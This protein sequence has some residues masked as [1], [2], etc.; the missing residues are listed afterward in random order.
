MI[1][2]VDSNI[3]RYYVQALC[4]VFFPGAKF[5][6]NEQLTPE[7]PIV[8]VSTSENEEGVSAIASFTIGDKCVRAEHTEPHIKSNVK[9]DTKKVAVGV[10]VFKVGEKFFKYSPSWGILTGVRPSKIA[11]DLL[12]KGLSVSEIKSIFTK[13]YFINPKKAALVIN[14][15][16]NEAKKIKTLEENTCSL[17]ISIPFCPTRCSYCSF[18]S[19]STNRLLSL[20]PDYIEKLLSDLDDT[21]QLIRELNQKIITVYIGGGTPSILS[22]EQLQMLF[23]KINDNIDV[24]SLSEYTFEAGRP[25]TITSEKLK[26]AK[27]MGVNRISINPQTLN[28]AVLETIGRRHTADD[29]YKAYDIVRESGIQCINTDLIAGLP[30]E[31]FSSFSK[32]V[33]AILK[34]HPENI[35]F[36]TFCVK[37][38]ADV[39]KNDKNIYSRVIGHTGQSVDYAQLEAKNAGYIPYYMYRQKNTIGNYENVGFSLEGFEG[40]YNIYMM[41]ELHS[42]FAVGAGAVSKMVSPSRKSI[43]RAFMPKY[44]YEYLQMGNNSEKKKEFYN[45]IRT[46]YRENF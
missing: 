27:E 4:M 39:L 11:G 8:E 35:T 43:E 33:D 34:L 18:V 6:E 15:A 45:K 1:L 17:Y 9:I 14:V 5:A 16:Q 36:H 37:K 20:I 13:Q 31:S 19:Y 10:A 7:T 26:L 30:G 28:D 2:K 46:F 44:P 25:D 22:A 3:N 38:A 23:G 29:F 24:A 21:F 32:T 42:I 41:E 12:A 40:L